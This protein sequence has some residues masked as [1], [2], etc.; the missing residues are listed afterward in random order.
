MDESPYK[1]HREMLLTGCSPVACCLQEFAISMF[2]SYRFKF[3]SGCLRT[4]DA[5]QLGIFEEMATSFQRH[6]HN[7]PD[8]VEVCRAIIEKR[9][10]AARDN[11]ALLM[12]YQALQ[13]SGTPPDEYL[14]S[15]K[16]YQMQH[17]VNREKGY[18][19]TDYLMHPSVAPEAELGSWYFEI[20]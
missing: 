3:S 4:F 14:A 1:Q 11:L 8:F 6:G 16:T 9:T 15:L 19:D 7:D 2:A 18:I 17:K 20:L 12:R 10:K 13:K 5:E